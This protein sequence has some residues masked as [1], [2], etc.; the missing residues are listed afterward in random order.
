MCDSRS[1][2]PSGSSSSSNRSRSPSAESN[3]D[4][5]PRSPDAEVRSPSPDSRS[6][7]GNKSPSSE[8]HSPI[9]SPNP[10]SR[11]SARSHSSREGSPTENIRSPSLASSQGSVSSSRKAKSP[12]VKS[13]DHDDSQLSSDIKHSSSQFD[14][15]KSPIGSPNSDSN[16]LSQQ[17]A[18]QPDSPSSPHN[19]DF[20]EPRSPVNNDGVEGPSSPQN[21]DVPERPLSPNSGS[22]PQSPK[23]IA[24]PAGDEEKDE[25]REIPENRAEDSDADSDIISPRKRG[26]QLQQNSSDEGEKSDKGEEA[27]ENEK[28]DSDNEERHAS[29]SES[30][31]GDGVKKSKKVS[32]RI[33]DTNDDKSD[34]EES[35]KGSEVGELIANIFGSSDEEEEFEGFGAAEVE[36]TQQ[37]EEEKKEEEGSSD[38]GVEDDK[39]VREE[40]VSDFD[41]MMERKK[42]M[43]KKKRRR[44]DVDI[45]NDNDDLIVEMV[46]KMR[47]VAEE[48]RQMNQQHKPAVGKLKMLPSVVLEL[49]KADLQT[50]LIENGILS[51]IT[52]WLAPLPDKSL[53]HLTI[54]EN[55]LRQL[56]EFPPIGA[57]ALK[58]SGIG[59]AVM[60][61]YKHPKEERRNRELA[62]KLIN[63]WSRPIFNVTANHKSMSREEREQRDYEHLPKKRRLSLEGTSAK[64]MD[65][66]LAGGDSGPRP[67]EKGF[68]GRARVPQPSTKDYVVR[69]KW[70]VEEKV[71]G[72]GKKSMNRFEK[73]MRNLKEKQ[74]DR[75]SHRAIAISISGNKMAI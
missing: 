27:E 48:D 74:K 69:P 19:N 55:L 32:K 66:A 59:K 8:I 68:I 29:D 37:V 14:K 20:A 56:T 33:T 18:D 31:D 22:P 46:R 54:R 73:K 45:I 6:G 63:E 64:D 53:P 12:D 41:L 52:D 47:E 4:L 57:E 9:G 5:G 25:L 49:K 38:E 2:S 23:E 13:P 60:Y 51:A 42:E 10:S 1:V 24:S 40:F 28:E 36:G 58:A 21:D 72:S 61:L 34:D 65:K 62:G 67:G 70:N 16:S 43:T 44:K 30:E 39:K 35:D 17:K 15:T 26:R 71:K 3:P 11:Q 75:S 7:Q 50:V